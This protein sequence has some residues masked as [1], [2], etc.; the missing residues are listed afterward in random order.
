MAIIAAV[1]ILALLAGVA[2][3]LIGE[4]AYAYN[5]DQDAAGL[6][7]TI[8][9]G[10]WAHFGRRFADQRFDSTGLLLADPNASGFARLLRGN[11]GAMWCW[12]R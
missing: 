6:P 4:A 5:Q 10:T 3:F 1:T 12:T 9:L 8:K 7:G 2:I 11:W